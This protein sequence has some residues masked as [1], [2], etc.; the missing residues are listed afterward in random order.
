MS[1]KAG[2]TGKAK[3]NQKRKRSTVKDLSAKKTSRVGD[4][5]KAE[6]LY[7]TW[8]LVSWTRQIVETGETATP[9]GKA[10]TGFLSYS[11]DGRML[12]FMVSDHRPR[13]SDLATVSDQERVELFNTVV[14][15][16][17]TFEVV[18]SQ[19]MH[20][21][22]ISWNEAWTGTTQRRNFRIDGSR[23]TIQVSPQIGIDGRRSTAVLIWDK[24]R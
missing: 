8:R 21:L 13:P 7:S 23:L 3:A 10:P 22:D 4:V 17:G 24:V 15:M 11:P 20:K 5:S 6:Q 19:V 1:K 9:F 16:G 2:E 12:G 14:A 18:G